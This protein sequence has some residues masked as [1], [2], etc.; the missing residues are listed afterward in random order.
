MEMG[1]YT[2]AVRHYKTDW[3]GP[4]TRLKLARAYE[5]LGEN[6]KARDAY[7]YFIQAWSDADPELQPIVEQ[8][9]QSFARLSGD[10]PG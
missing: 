4:L 6:E 8:A 10:S 7:S 2:A 9:K 5:M 1:D 3:T